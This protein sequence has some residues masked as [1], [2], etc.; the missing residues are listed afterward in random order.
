MQSHMPGERPARIPLH[1]NSNIIN[2]DKRE[3]SSLIDYRN[4]NSINYKALQ[5]LLWLAALNTSS[6]LVFQVVLSYR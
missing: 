6:R 3:E 5:I 2:F 1:I 4:T